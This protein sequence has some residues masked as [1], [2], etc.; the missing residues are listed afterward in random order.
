MDKKIRG[1]WII[2]KKVYNESDGKQ[3]LNPQ[4]WEFYPLKNVQGFG[5]GTL[6]APLLSNN[7]TVLHTEK[8]VLKRLHDFRISFR[9]EFGKT[10]P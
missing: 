4:Y 2:N 7:L 10:H 6:N 5:Y 8:E 3:R 9:R 1:V